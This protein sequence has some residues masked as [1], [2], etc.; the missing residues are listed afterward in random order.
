MPLAEHSNQKRRLGFVALVAS[1]L[2]LECDLP[3]TD[4]QQRA[5]RVSRAGSKT[6]KKLLA[7]SRLATCTCAH[8][9]NCKISDEFLQLHILFHLG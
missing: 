5:H 4:S 1:T 2:V 8:F 9:C 3:K 7:R 6:L